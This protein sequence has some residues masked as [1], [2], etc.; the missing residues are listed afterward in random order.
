[1]CMASWPTY[2]WCSAKY[3]L[4]T[5]KVQLFPSTVKIFIGRDIREKNLLSNVKMQLWNS[6]LLQSIKY[7]RRGENPKAQYKTTKPQNLYKSPKKILH[8]D[9]LVLNF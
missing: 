4:K 2:L 6:A 1:M 7:T 5:C 9:G 8:A 3:Y